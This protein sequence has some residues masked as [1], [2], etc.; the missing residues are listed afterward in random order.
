MSDA[1]N[2]DQIAY[3]NAKTGDTWA[4]L[5]DQLDRQ[6]APLGARAQAVLGPKAG[7]RI[8]DIGCGCGDTTLSLARAVGPTGEAVGLDISRPMLEV[9]RR[10]ASDSGLNA[11]FL[12]ADA[13][14]AA[15]EGGFDGL[16][17]RFGVMFF[18]DPVA[19][20]RNLLGALKPGGR[21]AFVCWRPFNEV[22]YLRLPLQV[23]LAILPEPP[24]PPDP[25]APG[26]FAFGDADRTRGIL[27]Q[28]G[29]AD[30]DIQPFD[31]LIGSGGLEETVALSQRVGPLGNLLRESPD[32][33]PAVIAALREA[34]SAHD[35]PDGVRLNGAVWIVTARKRG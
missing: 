12:E 1:G 29:F 3:W 30:I 23:A 34:L 17:S 6:L 13:Q 25:T 10:R 31:T 20:F 35:G 7:E 32:L 8:L 33:A 27:E 22:E 18:A 19:A 11:R 16:Y 24:P 4:E 2:T 28:A 26:P 9:A 14:T 5:Q 21:L 15:L